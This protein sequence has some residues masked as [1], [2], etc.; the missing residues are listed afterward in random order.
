MFR[1]RDYRKLRKCDGSSPIMASG[2]HDCEER[3]LQS[4][5]EPQPSKLR[6]HQIRSVAVKN[7]K[8]V[9]FFKK[10]EINKKRS[11]VARTARNSGKVKR[12]VS[13]KRKTRHAAV[14]SAGR[15]RP[16]VAGRS[17]DVA[18]KENEMAC[19]EDLKEILCSDHCGLPLNSAEATRMDGAGSG[20]KC[21]DC[22][23]ELSRDHDTMTKVLFGRNLRLNVA[24]TLWRR[25]AGE[26]IA[27]L[28]RIQDTGVLVDCLPVI[29][30][31]LQDEKPSISIGCCVE[32][33]PLVRNI[34]TSKYEEYLI[35]GLHWVQSVVKKWWPELSANS[36]S[37]QDSHSDDRNIQVMK[38]QLQ[39]LWERGSQLSLVPGTTGEMAKAIDS[40]RR[41]DLGE[42]D[43]ELGPGNAAT[44]TNGD[45]F[46]IEGRAVVPG[47]KTQDWISTARVLVEGEEHVGFLKTDGSFAVNDVPS[48][49]YV[50]EIVSPGYSFEPVRVDITSKGKMRARVVNNIK[51]SEVMRQPYP[52][53]MRSSGPHSYFIKRETWGW[54]DF[55]MNPMVLMMVLPLLIIVLLPKVVNTND[56][57]MR[58]EM[59]QSM[60]MLNPNHELPDVSEFMTKLFSSKSSGKSGSSTKASK[61][62]A[63]K[64]R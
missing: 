33:L 61:S 12:V 59:E 29:T 28:I 5:E 15:Q 43:M 24:L 26:L 31:S 56:P 22:F 4:L 9:D 50:L 16:P 54:T 48:G 17:C 13:S 39:E 36:R 23:T 34:L 53:Q 11:P 8:E 40:S 21:I 19:A 49:S 3:E 41:S 42:C 6:K 47:I 14:S 60:N 2:D 32:L 1:F 7:M 27:Y 45:R 20:S 38:Q 58:R 46:R 25:N 44:P 55:L 10:E 30:K 52:L 37:A 35:V 62:V 57:E 64:R 18:N 63:L 51:T